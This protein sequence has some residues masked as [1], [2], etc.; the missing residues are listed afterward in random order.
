MNEKGLKILEY[1]KI[2]LW[3]GCPRFYFTIKK[4]YYILCWEEMSTEKWTDRS[5]RCRTVRSQIRTIS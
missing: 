4:G 5:L 3:I 2:I 1:D